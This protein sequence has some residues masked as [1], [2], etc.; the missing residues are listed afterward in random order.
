MN[1]AIQGIL[2]TIKSFQDRSVYMK[3]SRLFQLTY[4]KREDESRS[5]TVLRKKR[6][7]KFHINKQTEQFYSE[8]FYLRSNL[9]DK[10]N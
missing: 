5:D 1:L 9:A 7:S 6:K 2:S 10:E 8:Q 3:K 4:L